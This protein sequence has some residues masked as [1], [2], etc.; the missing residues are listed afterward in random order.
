M[1]SPGE[2]LLWRC[3]TISGDADTIATKGLALALA[4]TLGTSFG[5]PLTLG[6]ALALALHFSLCF[7]YRCGLR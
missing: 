5:R 7:S 3:S 6:L 1:G 2:I 4:F